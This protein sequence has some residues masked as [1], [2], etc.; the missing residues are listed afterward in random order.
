MRLYHFSE[1]P[2]ISVF[3][4]RPVRTPVAR[5]AGQEWLNGPLVWAI[6]EAHS[7]LYLFPRDC[8]RILIGATAATT[9]IDRMR[10]MGNTNAPTI[11]YIETAWAERLSSAIVHRYELPTNCFEDIDD[12]GMWVSKAQVKPIESQILSDLPKR[13]EDRRVELRVVERLT[14]L[15]GVWTSTLHASGIRLRSAAGWGQPELDTL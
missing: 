1:D 5:P 4:P 3:E 10:W 6:D 15:K 7:F 8:P 11:A 12:V 2:E 13:L 14:P 9:E